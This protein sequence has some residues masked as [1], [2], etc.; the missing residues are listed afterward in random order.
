[1]NN[2]SCILINDYSNP[3]NKGKKFKKGDLVKGSLVQAT[4][5]TN[6][7]LFKTIDGYMIPK[8]YLNPINE[9]EY[10]Y[11]NAQEGTYA[12]VIEDDK[13]VV[14]TDLFKKDLFSFTKKK[15]V[16]SVNGAIAG[17]VIGLVFAMYK[18]KSKIM[19]S[20]LGSVA[21]FFVGGMYNNFINEEN[22]D[23]K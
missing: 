2:I 19:Y 7:P 21:G 16:A 6:N 5:K 18:Q 11:A 14:K 8:S 1:M 12:E 10:N 13:K 15:S 4:L 17:A 3:K 20:A 22:E 9:S 23:V